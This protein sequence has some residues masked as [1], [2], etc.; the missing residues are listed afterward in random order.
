M[1]V[2]HFLEKAAK[3][4]WKETPTPSP[5]LCTLLETYHFPGN[6]RELEGMV[7]DAVS[8]HK[9]GVLSIESFRNKI[10]EESL[11]SH[12]ATETAEATF[13]DGLAAL[14]RLPPLKAIERFAIAEAL[15]RANGNQTIAAG[16][17][18]MTR[19]ALNKRV[20]RART[21]SDDV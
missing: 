12:E 7:L 13:V 15:K 20:N 16:L 17:L 2:S 14:H 4:L 11:V 8:Q 3:T 6:V 18:G 1:L 21:S 5:E 9:G 19:Q 10:G